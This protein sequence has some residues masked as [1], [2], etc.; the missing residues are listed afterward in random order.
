MKDLQLN[1]IKVTDLEAMVAEAMDIV[2]AK[3]DKDIENGDG[4]AE[5]GLSRNEYM[6][7]LT[8]ALPTA[9]SIK[10]DGDL[11]LSLF[12]DWEPVTLAFLDIKCERIH[13]SE[14][15]VYIMKGKSLKVDNYQL[16]GMDTLQDVYDRRKEAIDQ[17]K[18]HRKELVKVGKDL[19]KKLREE[20]YST[21]DIK[22][23]AEYIY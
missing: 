14:Q 10:T 18:A 2:N 13:M 1:E 16:D 11:R 17:R 7:Q 9:V 4:F 22:T 12:V 23:I 6:T 20:G 5:W 15:G 8:Y 19:A 3:I 21:H